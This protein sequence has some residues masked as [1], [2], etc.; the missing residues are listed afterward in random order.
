MIPIASAISVLASP[1]K[2]TEGMVSS[3]L[4]NKDESSDVEAEA[5]GTKPLLP[6]D[7]AP[8]SSPAS[9]AAESQPEDDKVVHDENKKESGYVRL[10]N[11]EAD[12]EL[13]SS[14]GTLDSISSELQLRLNKMEDLLH[15]VSSKLTV[16]NDILSVV[17]FF[18]FL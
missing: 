9:S 7:R 10:G 5:A 18:D 2:A 6:P 12:E 4:E 11:G 13:W 3:D 16:I 15:S 14:D 8:P 17:S 1:N